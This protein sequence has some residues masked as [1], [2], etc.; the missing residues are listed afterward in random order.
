MNTYNYSNTSDSKYTLTSMPIHE[1]TSANIYSNI[2]NVFTDTAEYIKYHYTLEDDKIV[3]PTEDDLIDIKPDLPNCGF[4]GVAFVSNR[5]GKCICDS[6][7]APGTKVPKDTFNVYMNDSDKR[8]VAVW[9]QAY[10]IGAQLGLNDGNKGIRVLTAVNT[11]LLDNIGLTATDSDYGRG[12]TFKINDTE[13][14]IKAD[15]H[16]WI[17]EAYREA[18]DA[19]NLS[20][21]VDNAKVFSIFAEVESNQYDTP[22]YYSGDVLYNAT[23]E[24]GIQ[25]IL[26]YICTGGNSITIQDMANRY[27]ST[28]KANGGSNDNNYGLTEEQYNVLHDYIQSED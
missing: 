23:N 3:I 9:C 15:S 7:Y 26:D 5:D 28:L 1:F 27:L 8:I 21:K 12:V 24:N 10:T 22:I 18:F 25:Q 13:Y 19:L 11:G 16:N 6:L 2:D 17:G 14:F 20:D 4:V